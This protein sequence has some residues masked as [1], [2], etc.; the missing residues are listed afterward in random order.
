MRRFFGKIRARIE[1]MKGTRTTG[2]V[3]AFSTTVVGGECAGKLVL[4]LN[5]YCEILWYL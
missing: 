5:E 3:S 4:L 1:G 2:R